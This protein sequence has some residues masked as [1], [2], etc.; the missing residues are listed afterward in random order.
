MKS[1]RKIKLVVKNKLDIAKHKHEIAQLIKSIN[2]L[3]V[4]IDEVNAKLVFVSV[5]NVNRLNNLTDAQIDRIQNWT[6]DFNNINIE[7]AKLINTL[8]GDGVSIEYIKQIYDGVK[9][10][11]EKG[12]HYLS[13]FTSQYVNIMNGHR[14]TVNQPDRYRDNVYI[15]GSCTARGTGVEDAMTIESFMQELCNKK[16]EN[17]YRIENCGIGCGS[18]LEDD[19]RHIEETEIGS[20]D[21]VIILEPFKTWEIFAIKKAKASYFDLSEDFNKNPV[22]EEWFLDYTGHTLP[23]GNRNIAK[24]IFDRLV[25]MNLLTNETSHEKVYTQITEKYVEN[26]ELK[27]YLKQI[28]EMDRGTK[29]NG[30]IV[31]NCN[32]FTLGHRYLIETASKLVDTLYIFVVEENRSFFSFDDRIMLVE[33]GCADLCNVVVIPSGKFIISAST[34][35]GYFNKDYNNTIEVDTSEDVSIFGRY[36]ARELNISKRFVGEEPLDPITNQYNSSMKKILPEFGIELIEIPRKEFEGGVISASRV[37]EY[38]KNKDFKS[39][40]GIVPI[41]TY[42]FLEEKY[43]DEG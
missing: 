22:Y 9:V 38:L 24:F 4:K 13:D 21:V 3:T 34:F 15:Y 17:K 25:E 29:L 14:L 26:Q 19:F 36:I 40:K 31:M 2:D 30:A 39:I 8:Y 16:Y 1:M 11:E 32:P 20:G 5:P 7:D 35:P 18:Y 10:F 37:R 23:A 6:F 28:K 43:M 41:S 12:C 33:K 42:A 27:A